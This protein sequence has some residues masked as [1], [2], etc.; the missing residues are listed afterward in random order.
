MRPFLKWLGSKTQII[1]KISILECDNY[2]EPF[3]GGGSTLFSAI[4]SGCIRGT[5]YASDINPHLIALYKKIQS[6]PEEFICKLAVLVQDYKKAH[7]QSAFYYMIR[8]EFNKH[9]LPEQFLFLNKTCFRGVYR[10][11]PRGFNVPF[12]H[13]DPEIFNPDH[14]RS[15]SKL[16]Q[17]VV[18]QTMSFTDALRA[19]GPGDFVYLDPPYVPINPTSFVEY[20]A[21]GFTEDNHKNLFE[22]IKNL[23]CQWLMSNSHVPMV[24]D[25]FTGYPM[26][27][28]SCRRAINSK[29]PES[30]ALEVLIRRQI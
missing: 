11:G 13:M 25:S 28:I 23:P 30:R 2:Y 10:E 14:I 7:E 16:I 4:E 24:L 8:T 6:D 26:E 9:H 20:V 22:I 21:K 12:G 19:V 15:V 1:D 18:F 5:V 17:N 27:V 3:L 29:N